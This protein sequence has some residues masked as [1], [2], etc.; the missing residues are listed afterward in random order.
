MVTIAIEMLDLE[1]NKVTLILFPATYVQQPKLNL[2]W[3][4]DKGNTCPKY[5]A[6]SLALEPKTPAS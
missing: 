4:D 3:P 6:H 1:R 5:L 2:C